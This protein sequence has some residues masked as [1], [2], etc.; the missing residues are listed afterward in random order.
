MR[1]VASTAPATYRHARG[2]VARAM[3]RARG[4]PAVRGAVSRGV[5]RSGGTARA[6]RAATP[7]RRRTHGGT[8]QNV[9]SLRIKGI[10]FTGTPPRRISSTQGRSTQP[11][12]AY[13]RA[14]A[15]RGGRNGEIYFCCQFRSETV[16]LRAGVATSRRHED[17]YQRQ[18]DRQVYE[19][20]L[21]I[22]REK[23][24]LQ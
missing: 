9:I 20:R 16:V 4:A 8:L 7:P 2:A 5:H 13:S 17:D 18:L 12:N 1:G 15:S 11:S 21:Q 24:R 6:A 23:Q 19:E 22:E 14:A 10:L 3:A